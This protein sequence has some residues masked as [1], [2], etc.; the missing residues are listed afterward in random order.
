LLGEGILKGLA[1]TA[2]NFAGSFVSKD[3]L[4]TVQ[5]PEERIA[6]IENTRDFPFLVYD[7]GDWEAGMRCVACQIC[8]KECPPKCI[9]IEKS[10]DKKPDF[11]G[12]MQIYP[13]RFDIDISV[14]MSCQICVEVCPFEAIKMDTEF[15][16]S[17]TDRFGGLLLDRKQ[18]SK[19]NEYY[20]KIHPT[21]AAEV[22]AR[23][24]EEKSKA[25][26]KAK[27]AAAAPK[28][29]PAAPK[30]AVV[31]APA[32]V[33]PAPAAPAAPTLAKPAAA[34]PNPPAASSASERPAADAA[35]PAKTPPEGEDAQ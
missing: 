29:A 34:A 9:Y 8:E 24:A 22:D 2:K 19:S 13:A 35:P 14:C 31:A 25:E 5:Y 23:L 4:T 28:P 11:V 6:P 21:E 27:A 33:A 15:E 7:G 32:S 16:L 30:P 17:T 20:H 18:L 1:E 12:K 10:K 3:R 26:A